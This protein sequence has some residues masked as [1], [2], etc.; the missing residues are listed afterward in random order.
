MAYYVGK[1]LNM[2]P[3]EILDTWCVP[4]L[5]VTYGIYANE[6]Q[7]KAFDSI[8]EFNKN[9]KGKDRIPRIPLYAVKFYTNEEFLEES[10]SD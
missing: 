1:K 7:K 9:A 3:A 5:I 10:E 8:N 2:N 4:Q 6:D